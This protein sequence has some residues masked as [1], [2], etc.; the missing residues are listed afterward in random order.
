MSV[1]SPFPDF[2]LSDLGGR[3]WRP[4]HLLGAPAVV[5]CFASW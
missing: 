4:E 1:G 3:V 5:F 2:A